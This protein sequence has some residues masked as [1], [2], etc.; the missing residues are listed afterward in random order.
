MVAEPTGATYAANKDSGRFTAMGVANKINA[1]SINP[2]LKFHGLEVFGSYEMIKGRTNAERDGAEREFNQL[3]VEGLYRFL[4]NEQAYLG[5][6]YIQAKG[7][8]QGFAN[9]VS[10]DRVAVAAGWFPTKNLLLK[11]EYVVQNY[12]DFAITD[13]RNEAKFSGF[14]VEAVIG[15]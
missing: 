4:P 15:F 7:T 8:P 11:G 14:V 2:F 12:K 5:A 10:M 9:E 1:I 3:A 6:R 13:Y